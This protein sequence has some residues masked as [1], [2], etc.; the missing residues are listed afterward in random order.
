MYGVVIDF[1]LFLLIGGDFRVIRELNPALECDS[2]ERGID[3][4]NNIVHGAEALVAETG[5]GG[6]DGFENLGK[7][8]G[9]I[10]WMKRWVRYWPGVV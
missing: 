9:G 4:P 6:G 2:L 5:L 10:A 1:K 3:R 8:V 7:V